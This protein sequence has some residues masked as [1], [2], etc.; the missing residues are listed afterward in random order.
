MRQTSRLTVRDGVA[1]YTLAEF[2][3]T[4]YMVYITCKPKRLI[5]G[6]IQTREHD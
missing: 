4:R 2:S 3:V 1:V 6:D 5:Q